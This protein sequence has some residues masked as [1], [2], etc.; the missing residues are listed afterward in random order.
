MPLAAVGGER[1]DTSRAS[2]RGN[3]ENP[4][5]S[6]K[7]AAAAAAAAAAIPGQA[8]AP[9]LPA[10]SAGP[11]ELSWRCAAAPGA[12]A[13]PG[14]PRFPDINT[15]ICAVQYI[16]H[17]LYVVFENLTCGWSQQRCFKP[18]ILVRYIAV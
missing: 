12:G 14:Q 15:Y 10:P 9:S 17:W 2:L 8:E 3:P 16:S 18:F 11:G 6:R 5:E 1:R 4:G 7:S 13:R